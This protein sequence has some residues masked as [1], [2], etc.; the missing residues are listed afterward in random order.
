MLDSVIGHGRLLLNGCLVVV[1]YI[2]SIVC[3][4]NF[5]AIG[6]MLKRLEFCGALFGGHDFGFTVT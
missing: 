2:F 3:F 6:A 1:V 4:W 5:N